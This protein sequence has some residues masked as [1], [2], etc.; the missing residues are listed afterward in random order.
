VRELRQ[1]GQGVYDLAGKV[2][3]VAGGSGGIGA[4][5]AQRVAAAGA[6]VVLGYHRDAAGADAVMKGLPGSGHWTVALPVDDSAAI[7]EAVQLV[8]D[9]HRAVDVLVNGAGITRRIP[10][11]E[12]D[13]LDDD[14]F[15]RVVAVNLRGAY[16][17][18]RAFAPLLRAAGDA[19]LLNISS[20]AAL[21]GTGSNI[22]YCAAKAG[23]ETVTVSLARVLAPEVRVLAISPAAVDTGFVPGRDHAAVAEQARS[24]PLRILADPDDVAVSVVGAIT[25]FRLATGTTFLIDG[26][27]HL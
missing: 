12:L 24:T 3:V 15:D 13:G 16:A 10:H 14:T 17:L 20:V 25:H 19:V 18:A 7:A 21:T 26:G 23:L 22:A 4:A 11:A 1:G 5:T 9:R 6:T 8:G 2:S 27:M